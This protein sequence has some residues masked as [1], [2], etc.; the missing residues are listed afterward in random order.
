MIYTIPDNLIYAAF[1]FIDIVGSSNPTLSTEKIASFSKRGT[2]PNKKICLSKWFNF[3][4]ITVKED[5]ENMKYF[6]KKHK[7]RNACL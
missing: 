7:R 3:L 2:N 4:D 6:L 5:K 1:F